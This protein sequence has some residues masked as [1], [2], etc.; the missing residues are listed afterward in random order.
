MNEEILNKLRQELLLFKTNH[1]EQLNEAVKHFNLQHQENAYSCMIAFF[2]TVLLLI[3]TILT[4]YLVKPK[5]EW[6]NAIAIIVG[7][8]AFLTGMGW[9]IEANQEVTYTD[10]VRK[11]CGQ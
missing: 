7:I 2:I 10:V 4:N 8:I 5:A 3:I 9:L 11:L 1:V 6:L